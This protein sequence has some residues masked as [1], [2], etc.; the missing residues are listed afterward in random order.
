MLELLRGEPETC[1]DLAARWFSSPSCHLVG[2]STGHR[3][4]AQK[5]G[6]QTMWCGPVS[7]DSITVPPDPVCRGPLR[8]VIC[9]HRRPVVSSSEN[10]AAREIL[11][12]I[13]AGFVICNGSAAQMCRLP[14]RCALTPSPYDRPMT[15]PRCRSTYTRHR[16]SSLV[17][18][19]LSGPM[20]GI[21]R[22]SKTLWRVRSDV[23]P[24]A[25]DHQGH[26]T[27]G[28]TFRIMAR[29]SR[30]RQSTVVVGRPNMCAACSDVRPS[31]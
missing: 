15:G 28:S 24:V 4:L 17:S 31:K 26:A 29:L 7:K 6:P 22:L 18:G 5:V 23:S 25:A 21:G 10:L 8:A 19:T 30:R 20:A 1:A 13:F 3:S 11:A 14:R 2:D 9:F 27:T 16:A 12:I